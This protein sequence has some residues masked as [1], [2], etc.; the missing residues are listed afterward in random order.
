[1][2]ALMEFE[3]TQPEVF[4]SCGDPRKGLPRFLTEGHMSM[5]KSELACVYCV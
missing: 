1:M 5:T 3:I 4:I 2:Y